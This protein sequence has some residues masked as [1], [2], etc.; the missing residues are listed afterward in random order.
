MFMSIFYRTLVVFY[1]LEPL[2]KTRLCREQLENYCTATVLDDV[3]YIFMY[4]LITLSQLDQVQKLESVL[5][6]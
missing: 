2:L 6:N 4:N 3:I 1:E 5:K